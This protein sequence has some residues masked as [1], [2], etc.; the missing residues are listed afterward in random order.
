MN[1]EGVLSTQA[2]VIKKEDFFIVYKQEE[3][4]KAY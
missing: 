2:S 3:D 4:E 1:L